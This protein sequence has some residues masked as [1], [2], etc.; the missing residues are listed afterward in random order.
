[1]MTHIYLYLTVVL[2][3]PLLVSTQQPASTD[4]DASPFAESDSILQCDGG[5]R[6]SQN[7]R[8]VSFGVFIGCN[9]HLYLSGAGLSLTL[10]LEPHGVPCVHWKPKFEARAPSLVPGSTIDT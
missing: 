7:V 2:I 6:L 3:L 10:F 1:M 9:A 4:P 5:S 8:V